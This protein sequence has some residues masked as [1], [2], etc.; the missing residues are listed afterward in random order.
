ERI[1]LGAIAAGIAGGGRNVRGSNSGKQE[2][3]QQRQA[4]SQRNK[5][6]QVSSACHVLLHPREL[7]CNKVPYRGRFVAGKDASHPYCPVTVTEND[8]VSG[9]PTRI[10][11]GSTLL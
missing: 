2:S 8:G 1:L 11:S 10:F 4:G 7:I 9:K 6:Q 3:R 5:R